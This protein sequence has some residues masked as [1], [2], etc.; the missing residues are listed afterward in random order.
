M[1]KSFSVLHT[2]PKPPP[3]V[4]GGKEKGAG[5]DVKSLP[6]AYNGMSNIKPSLE[7]LND[8]LITTSCDINQT[9]G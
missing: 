6:D 8:I 3:S 9:I 7:P 4:D 5:G 2:L 1:G